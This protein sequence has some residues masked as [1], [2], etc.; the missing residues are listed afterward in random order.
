ME[1]ALSARLA[2]GARS[3]P[4]LKWRTF[5]LIFSLIR[6]F[7]S[8]FFSKIFSQTSDSTAENIELDKLTLFITLLA[9]KTGFHVRME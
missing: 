3:A 2:V 4:S 6:C 1:D 5:T 7:A 9:A 8:L